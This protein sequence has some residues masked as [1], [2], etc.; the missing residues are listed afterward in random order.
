MPS[1][2]PQA[3]RTRAGGPHPCPLCAS[4]TSK[5]ESWQ[6]IRFGG[7]NGEND[8][9]GNRGETGEKGYSPGYRGSAHLGETVQ[10]SLGL[11]SQKPA[12]EDSDAAT[13][14]NP[15]HRS[16]MFLL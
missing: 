10:I 16:S 14:G 11:I 3:S 2:R 13:L 9:R 4:H 15:P 6:E 5:P 12:E 7:R 8:S 1:V